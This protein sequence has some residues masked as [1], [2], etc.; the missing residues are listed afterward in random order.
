ML[1]NDALVREVH[2]KQ[3][4]ASAE[5]RAVRARVE[6]KPID[7]RMDLVERFHTYVGES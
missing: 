7:P 6:N 5:E 2:V 4:R 1:E 3:W